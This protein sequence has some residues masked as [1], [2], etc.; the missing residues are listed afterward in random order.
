MINCNEN[1]LE[2]LVKV[3]A[4]MLSP[5]LQCRR[6]DIA[7]QWIFEKS[8]WVADEV[9]DKDSKAL[10]G[11]KL[12]SPEFNRVETVHIEVVLAMLMGEGRSF[13]DCTK[14]DE[15][16][17]GEEYPANSY[18]CGYQTQYRIKNDTLRITVHHKGSSRGRKASAIAALQKHGTLT[19]KVIT[20]LKGKRIRSREET[21][22][23][24]DNNGYSPMN[25]GLFQQD[26][27]ELFNRAMVV[28]Y[29]HDG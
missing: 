24:A 25:A 27:Q 18:D 8:N 9:Y 16:C 19:W 26:E 23:R 6:N 13:E 14:V 10:L 21:Q 11:V 12:V 22:Y 2:A 17:W 5:K 15:Q 1:N 20:E 4:R 3:L 7:R 28:L 29:Q